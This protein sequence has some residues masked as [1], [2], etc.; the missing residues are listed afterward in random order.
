MSDKIMPLNE[1]VRNLG[2]E[3]ARKIEMFRELVDNRKYDGA[4]KYFR[5]QERDTQ[6]DLRRFAELHYREIFRAAI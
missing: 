6:L 4:R 1:V 5:N 2:E 3:R